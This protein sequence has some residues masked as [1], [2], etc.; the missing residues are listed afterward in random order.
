MVSLP[1]VE[2]KNIIQTK[3]NLGFSIPNNVQIIVQV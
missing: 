3:M 1:L 2:V